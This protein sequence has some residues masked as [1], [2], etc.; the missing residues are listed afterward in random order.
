MFILILKIIG[1]CIFLICLGFL[2]YWGMALLKGDCSLRMLKGKMTP[3]KVED[4]DRESVVLSFTIPIV[5]TGRQIGTI[6]DAFVR[7]YLPFE[8]YDKASVTATLTAADTPRD[9]GYWQAFIMEIRKPKV[10]LIKLAIKGK[11][12]NIL[13]DLEDFPDMPM[14]I[15]YQVVARSDYYYAKTRV[16]LTSEDLRTALYQYTSGVRK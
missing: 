7:T 5:N 14:D 16:T 9:D 2:A 8:Q 13:R 1:I 6:M 12:G 15:I 3:L 11:S 10:F 4:M